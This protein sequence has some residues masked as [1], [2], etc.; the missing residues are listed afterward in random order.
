MNMRTS[1]RTVTFRHPFF[2]DQPDQLLPAGDY[3]VETDE[4]LVEGLSFSA[5]RR[6]ATHLYVHPRAGVTQ[7]LVVNPA[8]LAAAEA[9]DAAVAEVCDFPND[10]GG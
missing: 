6:V 2:L 4:E 8:E 10:G 5:Y 1:K 9:R 3:L 7:M